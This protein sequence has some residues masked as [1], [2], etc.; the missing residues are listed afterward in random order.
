MRGTGFGICQGGGA[1]DAL[2]GAGY[3]DAEVERGGRDGMDGGVGVCGGGGGEGA[4]CSGCLERGTSYGAKRGGGR[5]KD[6]PL[7]RTRFWR[8]IGW[9]NGC[10]CGCGETAGLRREK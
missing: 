9:E 10:G 1:P 6:L 4:A 7:V 8:A 5:A 3:E 2:R